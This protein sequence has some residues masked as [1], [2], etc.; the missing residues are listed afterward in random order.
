MKNMI[1]KMCSVSC[2]S[3]NDKVS[4]KVSPA[5]INNK[6]HIAAGLVVTG[7]ETRI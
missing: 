1:H 4:P 3:F 2:M 5:F 6:A 7:W